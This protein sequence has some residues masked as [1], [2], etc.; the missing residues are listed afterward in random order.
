MPQNIENPQTF[1]PNV[2]ILYFMQVF[3]SNSM[4]TSGGNT[5]EQ[6]MILTPEAC[7]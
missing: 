7:K 2:S 6:M 5:M 1:V 4:E 3:S